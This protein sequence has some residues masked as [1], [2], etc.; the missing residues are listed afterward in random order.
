MWSWHIWVTDHNM[1]N[2]I[3][4]KNHD[5][6]TSNFM[7]VPLGWC[8]AEVRVYDK[9]TFHL[10]VNQSET[11]GQT[12]S[13]DIIQ[14]SNDSTYEYG[15]NAPY[16]QWGRKD[17]FLPS[18]GMGN[19]DKPYYDNQ[20]RFTI[21]SGAVTTNTAIIHPNIYYVG[22]S[23]S[24][25]NKYDYWN[26]GNTV[27]TNNNNPV[28]KTIYSPSPTGFAEPKTAAFTGFTSSGGNQTSGFNVSGSFNKGWNFYCQPNA[29]GSTVFF[30][31]LGYRVYNTGAVAD[32]SGS[33][34]YWSAGPSST[35]SYARYLRFL[36]G[37]V[38][39]QYEYNRAYGF[40]VRSAS[41]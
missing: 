14:L 2:T 35:S 16:Y 34:N 27:T 24:S 19:V 39:P 29:T 38:G 7:E 9:R 20:Y 25:T 21:T 41:E 31:A 28:Y 32:V 4:V 6:Y 26:Y 10:N 3:A 17:P 30:S 11:G 18:N 12:A 15:V 33:G 23:W 40:S 8:D 13:A 5:G 36:S 37:S 22:D 1:S